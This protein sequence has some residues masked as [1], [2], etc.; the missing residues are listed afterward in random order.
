MATAT[1]TITGR[2]SRCGLRS[3]ESAVLRKTGS[4]YADLLCASECSTDRCWY[5]KRANFSNWP[6][7]CG[8]PAIGDMDRC[9]WK[10]GAC[11]PYIGEEIE[12]EVQPLCEEHM[13]S[14]RRQL[15]AKL[16]REVKAEERSE[17]WNRQAARYR[18]V[19][20]AQGLLG[21]VLKQTGLDTQW[22]LANKT[23][24]DEISLSATALC[25]LLNLEVP[26]EAARIFSDCSIRYE[27]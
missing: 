2:C 24:D 18:A 14:A 3:N 1:K 20:A 10:R 12:H 27:E 4:Y 22:V 8:K 17:S 21:P 11:Y 26:A 6:S 19:T 25:K 9:Y 5:D 13:A 15:G 16:A 23:T 7:P